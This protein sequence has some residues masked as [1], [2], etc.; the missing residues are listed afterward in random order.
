MG[1]EM[2]IRDRFEAGSA[3]LIS[4]KGDNIRIENN[5]KLSAVTKGKG[6]GGD[7][8]INSEQ[9]NISNNSI[10]LSTSL[11]EGNGGEIKINSETLTID[12]NSSLSTDSEKSNGGD[13][14]IYSD[15]LINISKSL[16]SSSAA[17][18]GGIIE[19]LGTSD[20]V[21]KDS[22]INAEAGND[23]GNLHIDQPSL[24]V[25]N[26]ASLNANAVNG[27][28]GNVYIHTGGFLASSESKISVSSEF[29]LEGSI[30]LKTPDTNV[31]SD[32]IILPEKLSNKHISLS[33]RCG[34]GI[35]DDQSSFF[36][37]GN[38]G[39]SIWSSEVYLSTLEEIGIKK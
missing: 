13:I 27:Q 35:N 2:C 29:G 9:I 24:F 17:K 5:G 18:N 30:N 23:G 3:G 20:V 28:G 31:G 21:I 12:K 4:I 19:L 10:V 6:E 11:G 14:Q 1:S 37:N 22:K 33:N 39:L 26:R 8:K 36:L 38:G 34:L 16:L 15:G 25:L 7:I 32:L